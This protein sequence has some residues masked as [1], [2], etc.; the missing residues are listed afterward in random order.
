MSASVTTMPNTRTLHVPAFD[1]MTRKVLLAGMAI[2]LI[3]DPARL[4]AADVA[5]LLA[6]YA[7]ESYTPEEREEAWRRYVD[8]VRDEMNAEHLTWAD[9]DVT[10]GTRTESASVITRQNAAAAL[11]LLVF[12]ENGGSK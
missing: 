2:N 3:E 11:A 10:P 6:A 9:L 1:A 7:A 4:G 8:A 12:G 5:V